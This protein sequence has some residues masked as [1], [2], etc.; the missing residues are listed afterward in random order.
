M[1]DPLAP[2]PECG[3]LQ[4][5][6]QHNLGCEAGREEPARLHD[7]QPAD[8]RAGFE[9]DCRTLQAFAEADRTRGVSHSQAL[10]AGLRIA[11]YAAATD[12]LRVALSRTVTELEAKLTAAESVAEYEHE[13]RLAAER[14]VNQLAEA[15]REIQPALSTHH[16]AEVCEK[17]LASVSVPPKTEYLVGRAKRLAEALETAILTLEYMKQDKV[18]EH[19]RQA[20]YDETPP[21]SVSPQEGNGE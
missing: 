8:T 17:A 14:A 12:D 16:E 13:E 21:V 19:L 2:C 10:A 3:Y 4:D 11:A 9:A 1:S 7:Q 18:A 15:L 20:F 5:T 6:P